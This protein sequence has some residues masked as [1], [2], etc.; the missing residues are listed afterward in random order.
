MMKYTLRCDLREQGGKRS[1][2]VKEVHTVAEAVNVLQE[3]LAM[4]ATE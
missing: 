1:M 3:M 4:E 2:L